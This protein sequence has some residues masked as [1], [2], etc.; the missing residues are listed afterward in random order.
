ML[1]ITRAGLFTSHR[2]YREEERFLD[3]V[4]RVRLGA[5]QAPG[6]VRS[7]YL[8]R[9][10]QGAERLFIAGERRDHQLFCWATGVDH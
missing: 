9:R 10:E 6:D 3:G 2:T 8:M 4:R 1:Q 7:S 5:E